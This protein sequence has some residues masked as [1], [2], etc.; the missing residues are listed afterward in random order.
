MNA[1]ENMKRKKE[2]QK[3]YY[4]RSIRNYEDMYPEDEILIKLPG[5]NTWT[6]GKYKQDVKHTTI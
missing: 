4:D 3:E 1:K 6:K 2:K 5:K